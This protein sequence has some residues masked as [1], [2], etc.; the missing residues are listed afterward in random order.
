MGAPSRPLSLT[1]HRA[2]SAL[3]LVLMLAGYLDSQRFGGEPRPWFF[4]ALGFW[5]AALG[6]PL[7]LFPTDFRTFYQH[8]YADNPKAGEFPWR[9][10]GVF[11][12]LVGVGFMLIGI[13]R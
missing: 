3:G 9:G 2:I 7:V 1:V 11:A 13:T 4:I 6:A 5:A 8:R 10:I 12:L